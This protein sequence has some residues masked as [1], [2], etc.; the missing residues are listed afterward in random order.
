[1]N[2]GFPDSSV[3]GDSPGKNTRVGCCVLLQG[4]F[5]TQ[6]LKPGLLHCRRIPYH[7]SHQGSPRILEWVAD[8]F[9]RG[10]SRPR[11]QTEVSCITGGLFTSWATSKALSTPFFKLK[12]NYSQES[13]VPSAAHQECLISSLWNTNQMGFAGA[14]VPPDTLCIHSQC[15][16][17]Q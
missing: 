1:M 4:I 3:H 14:C 2:C 8:A 5:P 11:N 15:N 16:L 7:L 6:E 12:R 13:W 10:S 9:S 17:Q